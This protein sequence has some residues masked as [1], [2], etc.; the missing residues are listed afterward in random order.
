[1]FWEQ[2]SDSA[3]ELRVVGVGGVKPTMPVRLHPA[4][5]GT[6]IACYGGTWS[7]DGSSVFFTIAH[8]ASANT[9][10][11]FRVRLTADGP[12]AAEPLTDGSAFIGEVNL[13]PDGKRIMYTQGLAQSSVDT[14]LYVIDVSGATPI[15]PVKVNGP[16]VAG[17]TLFP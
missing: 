10:R 6:Q 4:L 11:L 7:P 17:G 14:A 8:Y 13:S 9:T 3:G 16:L 12:S 5:T 2:I 15:Q 1:M